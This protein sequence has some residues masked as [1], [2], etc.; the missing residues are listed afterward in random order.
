MPGQMVTRLQAL[1]H[2]GQ[3]SAFVVSKFAIG[4]LPIGWIEQGLVGKGFSG[5]IQER[6]TQQE[7][8]IPVDRFARLFSDSGLNLENGLFIL[9]GPDTLKLTTIVSN[10]GSKFPMSMNV[11]GLNSENLQSSEILDIAHRIIVRKP[12]TNGEDPNLDYVDELLSEVAN[13]NVT[14]LLSLS[15]NPGKQKMVSWIQKILKT[16]L[17]SEVVIAKSGNLQE[18]SSTILIFSRWLLG[19]DLFKNT[20]N[21][22]STILLMRSNEILLCFWNSSQKI[23]TFAAVEG[24]S[25]A[26]VLR[27][28]VLPLWFTSNDMLSNEIIGPKVVIERSRAHPPIAQKIHSL[29]SSD[30]QSISIIR[31]RLLDLN[32]QLASLVAHVLGIEKRIYALTKNTRFQSMSEHTNNAIEELRRI[33]KDTKILEDISARLQLM[34]GQLEKAGSSLTPDEIQQIVSKMTQLRS[35]IEKIEVEMN[36][37]D[38]RV[39]DIESLKFK[40]RG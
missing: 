10:M 18:F 29:T 28:F 31:T 20:E 11:F 6:K 14:H 27:K 17:S 38:S 15:L 3:V 4:T 39:S 25:L 24:L 40:S 12:V 35:L 8:I 32:T 19:L 26:V 13:G 33:E 34:E 16:D 2:S 23:A 30:L 7:L 9:G 1:Y 21:A 22:I 5:N 36:Q 37:L